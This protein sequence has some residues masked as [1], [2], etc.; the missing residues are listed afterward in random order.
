MTNLIMFV[1]GILFATIIMPIMQSISNVLCDWINVLGAK[2]QVNIS[3]S[4]LE[5][6]KVQ[7][8]IDELTNQGEQGELTDCCSPP[9][10][11]HLDECDC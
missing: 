7:C 10:G 5:I 9:M 6:T 8:K 2:A 4:N 11:F 1:F 3:N